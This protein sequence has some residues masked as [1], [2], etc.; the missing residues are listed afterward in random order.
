MKHKFSLFL[1]VAISSVLAVSSCQS[2]EMTTLI[3]QPSITL[4]SPDGELMTLVP[5]SVQTSRKGRTTVIRSEFAVQGVVFHLTDKMSSKGDEI[6][7]DRQLEIE[8]NYP[9][10]GFCSEAVFP[11]AVS[12]SWEDSRF[13][14]PGIIY[15]ESHTN[16][17]SK[18]GSLYHDAGFFSVREDLMS[19]PLAAALTP[20]GKWTAVL[21]PEPKGNTTREESAAGAGD[22]IVDGRLAFG[23]I[24]LRKG[25]EGVD[26]IYRYPGSCEEF[27]GRGPFMMPEGQSDPVVRGRF[28]PVTEG[29]TQNYTI[30]VKR[31]EC[32]SL[33]EA[34]K[35]IWRWAW[36]Q[37]DPQVTPVDLDQVRTTLLDHLQARLVRYEGRAGIPFV[38]DAVSGKPGSFRPTAMRFWTAPANP[39]L[40]D[41][42]S[43]AGELGID[44]DPSAAELGIWPWAVVGFCG[45]HVELAGQFLRES[46]RDTSARGRQFRESAEAIMN[47][48]VTSFPVNPPLGEGID[49]R[50]GR[51]GNIHGGHA[52]GVRPIAEDMSMLMELLA[53]EKEHGILHEDWLAWGR[54][55]AKWLLA[56]QREDGSFPADWGDDGE[57]SD[58]SGVKSYAPIPF[59]VRLTDFTGEQ[60][61]LEAAL[62]AGEALWKISGQKGVYCGATG[63]TQVADKESGML[64]LNAFLSLYDATGDGKWLERAKTAADYT[65]SW[66]WIWNV[67]M[68]EGADASQLGWKPGVPTTGVNGIGSNDVGGVDQYLDWAVPLYAELYRHSGDEHYLDVAYILLHGTK[69]M[70]ALPGRSYDMAGPGWQQE[71]WRMGPGRGVGAH[72]TWLPWISINHL[73]GITALED[74]DPELYEKLSH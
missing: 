17:F 41:I 7:L 29:F 28:H 70:L 20:D 66:I 23:A 44:I 34:E 39:E 25:K 52:F 59:F 36:D 67:P 74:Y 65:E 40:D 58:A 15:G 57:V 46:Y 43:W 3:E 27:P 6:T 61:W 14:I 53:A 12:S 48:L 56:Q 9:G 37:L 54:S 60:I 30:K 32:T 47:T 10:A 2:Q 63:S 62:K 8:G 50:T 16:A 38:I 45:K 31:G 64:S 24:D 68:P 19:A 21:N 55:H 33:P 73:H 4:S 42:V 72:R 13:I 49:L 35:M 11:A 71:H 26:F 22:R 5:A 1:S 69:A 51:V 18:G